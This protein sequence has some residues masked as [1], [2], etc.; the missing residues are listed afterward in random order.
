MVAED[1]DWSGEG[2]PTMGSFQRGGPKRIGEAAKTE[3]P[4]SI[5]GAGQTD[6]VERILR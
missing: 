6:A 1:Q 2:F 3:G 4:D 5:D